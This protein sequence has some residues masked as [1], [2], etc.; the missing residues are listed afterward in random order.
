MKNI[1]RRSFLK[2]S[3]LG[4]GLLGLSPRSWARV[5]G[6]NDDIRIAVVG[7]NG[8]G[9]EHIKEW[10]KIKGVRLVGLCDVDSRILDKGVATAKDKGHDVQGYSDIRKLLANNDID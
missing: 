3:A 7:F 6:A 2:R 8:R 4:A 10:E 9:E 5:P 1:T